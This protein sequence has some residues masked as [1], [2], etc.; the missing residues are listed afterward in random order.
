MLNSCLSLLAA[1]RDLEHAPSSF[2]PLSP[3]TKRLQTWRATCVSRSCS[4]EH[5]PSDPSLARLHGSLH[6]LTIIDAPLGRHCT[7]I[8]PALAI[9]HAPR[10]PEESPDRSSARTLDTLRCT[11]DKLSCAFE[12]LSRSPI[13]EP[14]E[15]L[16][17]PPYTRWTEPERTEYSNSGTHLVSY[18]STRT[19]TVRTIFVRV[20]FRII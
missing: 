2:R 18:R 5:R 9:S 14:I 12:R 19:Y 16:L 3:E 15:V 17:G 7:Q 11:L 10:I 8:A 13:P 4:Y 1:V 6:A 20:R